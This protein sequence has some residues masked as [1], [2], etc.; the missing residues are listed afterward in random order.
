LPEPPS[1]LRGNMLTS[2]KPEHC[3]VCKAPVSP[4]WVLPV[5]C[6]GKLLSGTGIWRS[7]LTDG[8]CP[9]CWQTRQTKDAE[10]KRQLALRIRL[11]MLGGG[12]K[13]YRE[14]RFE[15]YEVT[16][17]NEL[18]FTRARAFSPDRDNLYLWGVCGVGKTHLA[19]ATARQFCE[20]EHS[21]EFLQPPRLMRR[22]R[23]KEPQEEQQ[24]ID[25]LI[26]AEVFVLDDL[27]VGGDSAY[28]R[29][30]FQEIL[31]GRAYSYRCGLIVTSKYSLDALAARLGDD[32]ISSRLA[33]LC[34]VIEVRGRDHRL[35]P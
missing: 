24:A 30:I 19:F 4:E 13:P 2:P 11:V 18:A 10:Q 31:D 32:T 26:R 27:G 9:A 25:R 16:G 14:F 15:S 29:Q 23:M 17:E 33:G 5:Y 34:R 22:V 7:Q 6:N 8:L 35:P 3:A 20:L 1:R 12:E 21:V 28:A